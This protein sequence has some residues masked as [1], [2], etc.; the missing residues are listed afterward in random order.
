MR[1]RIHG[2]IERHPLTDRDSRG[3]VFLAEL[4]RKRASRLFV[5]TLLFG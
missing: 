1:P 5:Q 4:G 2:L 3:V